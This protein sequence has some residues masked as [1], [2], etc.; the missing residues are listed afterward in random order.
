MRRSIDIAT[1][2]TAAVATAVFF[3]V[4]ANAEWFEIEQI[5][6]AVRCVLEWNAVMHLRL[7]ACV[8]QIGLAPSAPILVQVQRFLAYTYPSWLLIEALG[9]SH[10]R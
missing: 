3:V 2:C 10:A 5:E 8:M 9:I 7:L 1:I 4:T 6:A